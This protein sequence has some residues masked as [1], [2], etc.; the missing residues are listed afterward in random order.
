[1]DVN[2]IITVYAP[3][4]KN[5][6]RRIRKRECATLV[7]TGVCISSTHA[8]KNEVDLESLASHRKMKKG[9]VGDRPHQPVETKTVASLSLLDLTPLEWPVL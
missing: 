1:M 7:I 4:R 8:A 3:C 2:T 9:V 6:F 5:V